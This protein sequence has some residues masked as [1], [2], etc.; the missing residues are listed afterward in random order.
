MKKVLMLFWAL[1]SV[2]YANAENI[3]QVTPC[4]IESGYT[5]NDY[6]EDHMFSIEMTNDIVGEEGI[7]GLQFDMYLPEGL[8]VLTDIELNPDR[9]EGR[10][11]KKQWTPNAT[12]ELTDKGNGHYLFTLYHSDLETISG[13]EGTIISFYYETTEDFNNKLCPIVIKNIV[14]APVEGASV[15]VESSTSYIKVGNPTNATLAMEGVIPSFV[16]EALAAE[17]A[18]STLD[19]TNVTASN[20][21]F[22]Y[23]PGRDVVA[24][25]TEVKGDV[26]ATVAPA[27]GNT[28]A[29][30]CLPF[31]AD[32][33]CYTLDAVSDGYAS[34]SAKTTLAANTPALVSQSVTATASNVALAAAAAE[35]KTAGYY[36]K[37]GN[38][39][40]VNGSATIPA[41]RGWWDIADDVRAFVIDGEETAI[42][43]IEGVEAQTIYNVAG[44]RMNKAQ[45]GVNI[46]GGKK[47]VIK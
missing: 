45:R 13:T 9:F 35:T 40:K 11:V 38:F 28:Y 1:A 41:L 26:A 43:A 44:M 15:E 30:V 3:L 7:T 12:A 17:T 18:I 14:L 23:V 6:D 4:T 37:G 39:C 47:V 10:I 5:E 42:N 8:T 21:T 33:A 31:A 29:T 22:A 46:V 16:N 27:A 32:F 36:V 20:G 2:A 34:F 25:A 24:P 19:L